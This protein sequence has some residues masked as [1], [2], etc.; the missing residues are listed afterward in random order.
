MINENKIIL[1][2]EKDAMRLA[3]PGVFKVLE[4]LPVFYIPI[5]ISFHDEDG[6][7]FKKEIIDYVAKNQIYS[8]VHS[9]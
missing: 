7:K 3:I 1:T 5:T 2:T 9:N 6:A 8:R 4:K